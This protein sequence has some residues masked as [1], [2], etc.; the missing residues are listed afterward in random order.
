M[1]MCAR[2]L[3][4]LVVFGAIAVLSARDASAQN[5]VVDGKSN[6]QI[7]LSPEA[8]AS[9]QTAAGELQTYFKDCM[10]IEL[11][12]VAV[13]PENDTPMIVLGSGRVA[14][15]LGVNPTPQELG[16]QGY[17]LRTVGPHLVIAGTPA[18]GTLYG[19]Y[20]FL[21]EYLGVRWYDP[22]VTKTP[23]GSD[24]A[25]P[26]LDRLVKP[27]FAWRHTGN[28]RSG[29]DKDFR[30]H[31]RDNSGNGGPDSPNGIQYAFEGTC[32]TYFSFIHPNEYFEQH[33]EYFSEIGGVR[34][35]EDTQLCLTNPDVLE[36]VTE[37]MLARMAKSP[38]IR[39]HNF[40]Q[41]DWY[42]YCECENCRAMNDKYSSLGATQFWFVNRVA[43]RTSKEFPDKLIGTLAYTYTDDPPKDLEIHANVAVWL[44]HMFPSCDSHPIETC[45]LDADYKRRALAWAELS[46]HLYIWHYTVDYAHYFTPFPNFR[47]M[48]ADIRF[49]R[50][51]GVEGMY[52]QAG[53]KGGEFNALRP[54]YGMKLLWN[55]DQDPDAILQDFLQGYY[56]AAWKPIWQY[57]TMLHDKVKNEDI[58]MHLYTNPAQGFLPDGLLRHADR[59][60]DQA[61]AAVEADAE[62]LER[63]RVA[64]MPLTYARLFPRN[65]YKIEEDKLV[66]QGEVASFA[67]AAGFIERMKAHGFN[68]LR[69]QSGAPEQLLMFAAFLNNPLPVERIGSAHLIVDVVPA[70]GG[71]ALRIIHRDSAEC[72]TAHNTTRNLYFPFAGGEE[73]RLG[74]LYQT[75]AN[76]QTTYTVTGR[77]DRSITMETT[78]AMG[79]AVR[80]TLTLAPDK[81]VLTVKNEITN[82]KDAPMPL[83]MRSHLEFELGDLMK[84][85]VSFTNRAGESVTRDMQPIVAGLR[86]GEYYRKQNTPNGTWT[87][88]GSKGLQVTQTFDPNQIDY[89]WLYAYPDYLNEL[90]VELWAR[91]ITLNPGE[92]VTFAND[93]EVGRIEE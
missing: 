80:R 75:P 36:I 30:T 60:F 27:P 93:I 65:G 20:D 39:Q 8:S 81:P 89:T 85:G 66:V 16:E 63:V 14:Q 4:A 3:G 18:A 52:L 41:M 2:T 68:T 56:G 28:L 26:E 40:S 49:Y 72:V 62:L 73:T 86:E 35:K 42:N 31:V 24:L 59:L 51:I 82:I 61:E 19:V 50:D 71:R 34:R 70:F 84:T 22:D 44:C 58:H 38:G 21:E 88:Q 12:V 9:E 48:A 78:N 55:P 64:R 1:Y 15:S 53:T 90:E 33:P 92:S 69:E 57:I 5:I 7:V 29:K 37:K 54:Y 77:T 79:F 83:I 47:A 46:A 67:E 17:V 10:G 74:T 43:E 13:R 32:H 45:P 87:F 91:P 11:P 76:C 6:Y 25:L 23:G